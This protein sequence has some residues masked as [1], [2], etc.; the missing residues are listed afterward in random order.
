MEQKTKTQVPVIFLLKSM[1]ASYIITGILLLF[2]ALLLYKLR[3]QEN[4]VSIGIILIYIIS[5]FF[6][7]FITGKK[8]GNRKF[9]WGLLMGVAYFALLLLVSLCI[10][11]T[12]KDVANHLLTTFLLCAGSGMLGGMIS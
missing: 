10:N 2:L 9:L 5:T 7:G 8:I 11:H 12:V 4:V 6:A 1:L 3:L